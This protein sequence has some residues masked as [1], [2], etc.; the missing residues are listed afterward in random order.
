MNDIRIS[1]GLDAEETTFDGELETFVLG[2]INSLT[3]QGSVG[4]LTLGVSSFDDITWIE[5][6]SAPKYQDNGLEGL[7][8]EYVTLHTRILFDPPPPRTQGY[9]ESRLKELEWRIQGRVED[10]DRPVPDS[11]TTPEPS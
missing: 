11:S 8:K 1:M 6:L 3:D 2:A 10:V 7:I 9:M 4:A 5:L